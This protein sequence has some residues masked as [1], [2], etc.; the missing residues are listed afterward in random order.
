MLSM[1]LCASAKGLHARVQHLFLLV[2][3]EVTE[4]CISP[5]VCASLS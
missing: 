4:Q 1:S 2:I 5:A 3:P